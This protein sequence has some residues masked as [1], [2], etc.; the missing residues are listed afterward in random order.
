[1]HGFTVLG[2][3]LTSLDIWGFAKGN[4]AHGSQSHTAKADVRKEGDSS[5]QEISKHGRKEGETSRKPPSKVGEKA[6]DK[7]APQG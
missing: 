4:C 2:P 5:L 3:T 6:T 7:Q 1:M